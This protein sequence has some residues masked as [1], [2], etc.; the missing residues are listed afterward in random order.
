MVRWGVL[1]A[2]AAVVAG[3]AWVAGA[4]G[5][6]RANGDGPREQPRPAD[7]KVVAVVGQKIGFF[8]LPRVMRE[9]RR[10]KTAVARL[11]ERKDRMTANLVGMRAMYAEKQAAIQKETQSAPALLAPAVVLDREK[12]VRAMVELSRRIEDVDREILRLLN[13]QATEIIVELYD[14]VH[15]TVAEL[16]RDHGL[17]AVVAYPDA[18]TPDEA[19]SPQIKELKLKPP[20]AYPFY[21]D[22]GVD[23][24]D[25]LLA[26][27]NAKF[28]AG[29]K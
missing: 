11:N 12:T 16:A 24:T 25:E 29:E 9:Y 3:A 17:S 28:A 14:E 23:Y 7:Q 18:A 15:A 26:K 6:S 13:N 4:T 27:L 22:P 21:L 19:L 5:P 2:G 8:N 10:A 1:A 20:A